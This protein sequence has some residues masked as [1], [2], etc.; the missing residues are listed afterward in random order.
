LVSLI[1][2]RRA[3]T[4]AISN[5][6]SAVLM[7]IPPVGDTTTVVSFAGSF[8]VAH[9]VVKLDCSATAA[10]YSRLSAS[11]TDVALVA[12]L[13]GST[14]NWGPTLFLNNSVEF[15]PGT[16]SRGLTAVI[17]QIELTASNFSSITIE[18]C[19]VAVPSVMHSD[20]FVA[21]LL[22]GLASLRNVTAGVRLVG[23]VVNA[24]N[25]GSSSTFCVGVM[26]WFL[27]G[28]FEIRD[29]PSIVVDRNRV[30]ARMDR[31]VGSSTS[32]SAIVV[33]VSAFV[34]LPLSTPGTRSSVISVT[35]NVV[36][37][38]VTSARSAAAGLFDFYSNSALAADSVVGDFVVANNP[39][40]GGR[41]R[42]DHRLLLG[43]RRR[44][45]SRDRERRHRRQRRS[46]RRGVRRGYI[47]GLDCGRNWCSDHQCQ[48]LAR[49]GGGG[50]WRFGGRA[51]Y[52]QQQ[53][54]HRFRVLRHNRRDTRVY[55]R[56]ERRRH[57]N[58]L[59]QRHRQHP[60]RQR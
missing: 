13:G 47:F 16:H 34:A 1:V 15:A 6:F 60:P 3:P 56:H 37:I 21:S 49:L 11:A 44:K 38:D 31:E 27:L 59:L 57:L 20:K 14:A 30:V 43:V 12:S 10:T 25:R 55:Y 7:L 17:V 41:E 4:P 9:C 28:D 22:N 18:N 19:S 33:L 5:A 45:P 58:Q 46:V 51:L 24:S 48:E 36:V 32:M 39:L 54:L 8:T 26:I 40:E 42:R 35:R 29:V 50:R 23:C 2:D 52:R 53:P